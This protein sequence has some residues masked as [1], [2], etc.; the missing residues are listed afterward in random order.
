MGSNI[1]WN[2]ESGICSRCGFKKKATRR[3]TSGGFHTITC[4]TCWGAYLE[5]IDAPSGPWRL[6]V[7]YD[8]DQ[9]TI[10]SLEFDGDG[11]PQDTYRSN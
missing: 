7:S 8:W 9:D 2:P 1:L 10:I 3:Y 5:E 4:E 6:D 11:T